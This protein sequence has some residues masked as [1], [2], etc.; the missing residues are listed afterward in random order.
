[1]WPDSD[2]PE[3]TATPQARPFDERPIPFGPYQIIARLAAGGMANVLLAREARAEGARL[4]VIKTVLPELSERKDVLG[5]F[6]DEIGLALRLVH[7]NCVQAY[8]SGQIKGTHFMSMEF[9]LGETVA[10][11][12]R[13]VREAG[14]LLPARTV[15]WIMA[16][17]ADG[18]HY[19]HELKNA[20]GGPLGLIHRDV[21]PQ[22][23]MVTYD[24][25]VK[26][27]DFGVAASKTKREATITGIIKGKLRYMSLEQLTG[28]SLDRRADVYSLGVVLF[29]A[30][31]TKRLIKAE[32]QEAI[33]KT[34]KEQPLPSPQDYRP[35]LP[36]K[37]VWITSRAL[38]L[39]PADR[40]STAAEMGAELRA[41]VLEEAG[42]PEAEL[43]AYVHSLLGPKIAKKRALCDR[44]LGGDIDLPA[45]RKAFDARRV[46]HVDI[47]PAGA[48]P[49]HDNATIDEL[50]DISIQL[51]IA[52]PIEWAPHEVSM[53]SL[54]I[55]IEVEVPAPKGRLGS[56][57]PELGLLQDPGAVQDQRL[58]EL[59]NLW[60]EPKIA[61]NVSVPPAPPPSD[62][63]PSE[64]VTQFDQESESAARAHSERRS[65][66][67]L[68]IG[69][70]L[71]MLAGGPLGGLI[72][73][74]LTRN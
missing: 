28:R 73:W 31:T 46:L 19:V 54:Q 58:L 38:A 39:H 26:I 25:R 63:V 16:C 29:E 34:L 56:A 47:H 21:S 50:D 32:T 17:A 59:A 41:F 72:T 35:D 30:L 44:V 61:R 12:V 64:E 14:T 60:L 24:G 7:P 49:V 18:L 20:S 42:E 55:P 40:Y 62:A 8:G 1:M 9:V 51:D 27:L 36:D 11:L 5:M 3:A 66:A 67:H 71:G 70:L 2:T 6:Q 52:T 10:A 13:E 68:F 37:L 65:S 69:L 57:I 48:M 4:S 74:L 43:N 22:N 15:A 33:I 45:I 53:G 23:V